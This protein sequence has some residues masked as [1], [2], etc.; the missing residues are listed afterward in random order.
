MILDKDFYCRDPA[1]V[2]K[3]ILGK[4]LVKGNL[5]GK[6]VETEA[7]YGEDDPASHASNG[8]TQRNRLMF[9]QGGRVYVY[10]CYG[11]YH[12]LNFTTGEEGKPGAVLIRAVEPLQGLEKMKSN[13]NTS[14]E[15]LTTGPGK[16]TEAF[17][18]TNKENGEDATQEASVI[19]VEGLGNCSEIKSTKRIGVSE[20]H[21]RDL[22]FVCKGS[23]FLSR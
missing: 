3:D 9:G 10:L 23:D 11:M 22:R 16:L 1:E 12:L 21:K 14:E 19:T 6:I 20:Q 7:Y 18:I 13:R 17:G 15:N 5:Q 8:K 2:A 4:K